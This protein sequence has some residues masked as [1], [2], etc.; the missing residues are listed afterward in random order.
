MCATCAAA[1]RSGFVARACILAIM[2]A[3]GLALS[4]GT[5][6]VIA[7]LGGW[8]DLNGVDTVMFVYARRLIDH[9]ID[10]Y[11]LSAGDDLTDGQWACVKDKYTGQTVLP[12]QPVADYGREAVP[13]QLKVLTWRSAEWVAFQS[14]LNGA[15]SGIMEAA[16]LDKDVMPVNRFRQARR[17]FLVYMQPRPEAAAV[18]QYKQ[19]KGRRRSLWAVCSACIRRQCA[20]QFVGRNSHLLTA[21]LYRGSRNALY[22]Y[23]Q[24]VH[25]GFVQL[26]GACINSSHV[27][28]CDW[29]RAGLFLRLFRSSK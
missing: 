27:V 28:L 22:Q 12:A 19:L 6:R 23:L 21:P 1:H 7:R 17:G 4:H 11:A 24:E 8:S 14:A 10:N 5:L 16:Y 9:R 26:S 3:K 2:R 25:F 13:L 18:Q 29:A 15:A 20:V